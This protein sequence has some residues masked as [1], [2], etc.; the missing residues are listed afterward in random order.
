[1]QTTHKARVTEAGTS[2]LYNAVETEGHRFVMDEPL[3]LGGTDQGPNPFAL[4][5]SALGA[6]TNMTLRLYADRKS[7]PLD[8]VETRVVH[9]ADQG[10]HRFLREIALEG[11]LTEEQRTRLLEIANRCPIHRLL[12][13]QATVVSEL[14][15]TTT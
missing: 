2:P 10:Q 14:A 8:Q 7:W 12:V 5:A 6:C 9:T 3:A 15:G 4:V 13:G 1:M 11:A